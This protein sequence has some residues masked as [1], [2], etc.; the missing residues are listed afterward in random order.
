MDLAEYQLLAEA[1]AQPRAYDFEYLV[2]MI[3]GEVGE[4][5]GQQA[6]AHWHGWP[7][8][9]LQKELVSEYGDV[10]WGT[11]LLLQVHQVHDLPEWRPVRP[12]S[13]WGEAPKAL[14]ALTTRAA[15]LVAFHEEPRLRHL[16][17]SEASYLWQQ[18]Q[19]HCLEV[20]G[21]HFDLV[22]AA[23]L[24]KLADRAKRGVLQGQG[25]HR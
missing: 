9:Q 2:P 4:L 24:A 15:N 8:E 19:Y 21:S 11:A 7:W 25:D 18:L 17:K 16:V 20:T 5:L 10:A 3:A 6:K 1:T 12:S 13:M 14:T 22:L 23:N